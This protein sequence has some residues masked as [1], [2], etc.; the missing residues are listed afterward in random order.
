MNFVYFAAPSEV[1]IDPLST[2]YGVHGAGTL[3]G[4][5]KVSPNVA[6]LLADNPKLAALTANNLNNSITYE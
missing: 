5:R 3:L 1:E 2:I 6:K 4:K